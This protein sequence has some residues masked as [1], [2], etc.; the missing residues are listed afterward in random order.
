MKRIAEGMALALLLA[1]GGRALAAA[2]DDAAMGKR[3]QDVLHAHQQDVY[4]CVQGATTKVEGEMLVRV[5]LG[6]DGKA[7]K[8]DVLKDQSGGGPVGACLTAKIKTWDLASLKAA[9]G[10]QVV[11]PLVFKPEKLAKGHKRMLVPMALQESQGPQRFLID[12]E[13]VGEPPLATMETL[14]LAGNQTSPAKSRADAEEEVALYILEGG[15]K[16]GTEVVKA[17]DVVWLGAHS[18]RPALVPLDKKPLKLIEIRAHG[19]GSGQKIVHGA[20]VKSYPIPGGKGTAKLLLDGTGAKLAV[21]ELE[22]PADAII[23]THKHGAQDEELY[24]LSGKSTATIGKE[25]FETAPGDALRIP[26]N[27]PH[28]VKVA[29]PLRAI[30]VYAPGGPEQRFKGGGGGSDGEEKPGKKKKAKAK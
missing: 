30:Q 14:T 5:M 29:E 25:S 8:A 10:D 18:D 12:E 3:V 20:D 9:A 4:G 23:P 24:I 7:A 1:G 21:D 2:E 28:S 13:T 27:M 16:L 11:F 15:F 22:A 17:G 26:A 19:E 6:E